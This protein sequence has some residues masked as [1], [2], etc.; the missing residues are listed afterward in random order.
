M[1]NDCVNEAII[2]CPDIETYDELLKS[3]KRDNWFET[4]APLPTND[5]NE[6]RYERWGTKW[7]AY[8]F[9]IVRRDKK[10]FKFVVWF[11][12]AWCPPTCV[13]SKMKNNF[14]IETEA[15][16]GVDYFG[17]CKYTKD[18][19][20]EFFYDYPENMSEL[21]KLKSTISWS[22]SWY[23]GD[24]ARHVRGTLNELE[25]QF[26]D[27]FK[28]KNS[29]LLNDLTKLKQEII[30]ILHNNKKDDKKDLLTEHRKKYKDLCGELNE[31]RSNFTGEALKLTSAS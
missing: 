27:E 28:E 25:Q 2:R 31:L 9:K 30:E 7:E 21:K 18:C 13:Y 10:R 4:F 5:T 11:L 3:F 6:D 26:K 19:E 17:N 8:E 24:L 12:T 14:G 16:F 22:P 15:K 20:E 1:P 23:S 29:T